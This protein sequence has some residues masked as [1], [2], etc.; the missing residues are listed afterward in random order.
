M[1]ETTGFAKE[2]LFGEF[3]ELKDG[4]TA[5]K[6]FTIEQYND[7]KSEMKVMFTK[8]VDPNM[9]SLS[10]SCSNGS[11]VKAD[12]MGTFK[13]PGIQIGNPIGFNLTIQPLYHKCDEVD[14][15]TIQMIGKIYVLQVGMNI[16]GKRAFGSLQLCSI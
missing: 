11:P 15:F 1:E 5:L 16:P 7:L 12:S 8:A 10:S 2:V 13:C 14:N 9:A 3:Q 4:G 6:D